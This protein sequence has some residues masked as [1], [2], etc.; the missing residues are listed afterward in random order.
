MFFFKIVA[1]ADKENSTRQKIADKKYYICGR[2]CKTIASANV[3]S[4]YYLT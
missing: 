3:I 2:G 4:F 1:S